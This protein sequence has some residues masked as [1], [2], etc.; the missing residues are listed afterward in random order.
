M[1]YDI[2]H[3]VIQSALVDLRSLLK[4][5]KSHIEKV[6]LFGSTLTQP[7]DAIR[8]VDFFVAYEGK[9]FGVIRD[10]LRRAKLERHVV[11]ED[12]EASYANCPK[13]PIQEP[14]TIHIVLYRPRQS[15]FTPKLERARESSVEVTDLV[16]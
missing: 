6:E 3:P 12:L 11:V 2:E 9:P 15:A 13:W 4:T 5:V 1:F 16:V 7:I 8:D 14:L 10:G